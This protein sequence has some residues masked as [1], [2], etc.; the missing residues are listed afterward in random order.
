MEDCMMEEKRTLAQRVAD[1]VAEF[2][3]SWKFIF[4]GLLII[5]IW[6][7]LNTLAFL[8]FIA[9]DEYPFIFLNLFLSLVAAFQ[10]PF[11]LMAQHRAEAKQDHA[12][13]VL[14]QEIKELVQKDIDL[15][16]DHKNLLKV[17]ETHEKKSGRRLVNLVRLLAEKKITPDMAIDLDNP[18]EP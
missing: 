15:T 4:S 18:R 14:F 17:I 10:A 2:G 7:L 9:F 6:V 8:H 12:Y 13:R 16:N 5:V 11:I 1:D 3:G